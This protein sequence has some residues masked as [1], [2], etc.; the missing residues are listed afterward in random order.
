[1]VK[2]QANPS[3]LSRLVR[4]TTLGLCYRGP[5]ARCGCGHAEAA[6]QNLGKPTVQ[7]KYDLRVKEDLD[8]YW[9]RLEYACTTRWA[10]WTALCQ[11]ILGFYYSTCLE[12]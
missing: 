7:Y 12:P 10:S 5:S 11:G 9:A 8:E 4:V 3:P 1:M 6:A 2:H